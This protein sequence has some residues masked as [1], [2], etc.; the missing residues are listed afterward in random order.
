MV[1]LDDGEGGLATAP[2]S[3]AADAA[4]TKPAIGKG[5]ASERNKSES[6]ESQP[7]MAYNFTLVYSMPSTPDLVKSEQRFNMTSMK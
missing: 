3:E 7:A 4:P 2:G 1:G 6:K 5:S